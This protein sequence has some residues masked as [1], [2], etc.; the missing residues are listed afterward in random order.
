MVPLSI[1]VTLKLLNVV[2]CHYV[3]QIIDVHNLTHGKNMKG[4]VNY[5][6]DLGIN[7]LACLKVAF[8]RIHKMGELLVKMTTTIIKNNV[9][10]KMKTIALSQITKC[11]SSD[12]PYIESNSTQLAFLEDSVLYIAKGYYPSSFTENSWSKHMVN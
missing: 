1:I 11:F 3:I 4:L 10:K 2:L 6:E 5:N 8:N 7:S 12:K 9:R